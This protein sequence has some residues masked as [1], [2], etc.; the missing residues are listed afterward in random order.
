M[1]FRT[2]LESATPFYVHLLKIRGFTSGHHGYGDMPEVPAKDPRTVAKWE[3]YVKNPKT[4]ELLKGKQIILR[5][6]SWG[7]YHERSCQV[8]LY[9]EMDSD[10]YTQLEE[11]E[12]AIY[13]MDTKEDRN[14]PDIKFTFTNYQ[15]MVRRVK[16]EVGTSNPLDFQDHESSEDY[17]KR[18][19]QGKTMGMD[20]DWDGD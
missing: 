18:M 7:S 9:A 19:V 15:D 10:A 4:W 2:F 17:W 16:D 13:G 5:D 20:R 14:D 11:L 6:T 1:N 8:D 3:W 12:A